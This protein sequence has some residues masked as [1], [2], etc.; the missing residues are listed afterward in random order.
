ME[1]GGYN[2][3]KN[4]NNN[5]TKWN[6]RAVNPACTEVMENER[7]IYEFGHGHK[8]IGVVTTNKENS[9]NDNYTKIVVSGKVLVS[10]KRKCDIACHDELNGLIALYSVDKNKIYFYSC[11][12]NYTSIIHKSDYL[13]DLN[14]NDWSNKKYNESKNWKIE[15]MILNHVDQNLIIIDSTQRMRIYETKQKRWQRM[16]EPYM[17]ETKFNKYLLTPEGAY[18]LAFRPYCELLQLDEE[19]EE[20]KKESDVQEKTQTDHL[21]MTVFLIKKREV[22]NTT[23]LPSYFKSDKEAMESLCLKLVGINKNVLIVQLSNQ[24]DGNVTIRG[25]HLE[26]N[27]Q[28]RR[29]QS[30]VNST[31]SNAISQSELHPSKV[32]HHFFDL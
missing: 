16:A 2:N 12:D 31:R 15:F 22:I 14:N 29:A 5:T 20:D 25:A 18:L 8:S 10:I 6:L 17:F 13:C 27:L 11:K 9:E 7:L 30:E 28:E 32:M 19:N 23:V 26:I 1:Y 3:N 4:N 21:E 24:N